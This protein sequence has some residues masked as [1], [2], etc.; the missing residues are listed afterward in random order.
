MAL[1][2]HAH[3]GGDHFGLRAGVLGNRVLRQVR[4]QADGQLPMSRLA[5]ISER[6]S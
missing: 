5:P 2:H 1:I 4:C 6:G 3:D